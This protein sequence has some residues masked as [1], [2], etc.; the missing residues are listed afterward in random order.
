MATFVPRDRDELV[1]VEDPGEDAPGDCI[2]VKSAAV[3]LSVGGR[4]PAKGDGAGAGEAAAAG[5]WLGA[6]AGW[7]PTGDWERGAEGA[8]EG[9]P[10]AEGPA[11]GDEAGPETGAG[12]EMNKAIDHHVSTAAQTWGLGGVLS[13]FERIAD[14]E[15]SLKDVADCFDEKYHGDKYCSR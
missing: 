11:V 6:P 12:K 9:L 5:P 14:Q 2:A 4:T 15:R 13:F 1:A 3:R 8:G 7:S 10:A